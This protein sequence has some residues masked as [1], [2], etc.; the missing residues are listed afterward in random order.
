MDQF[1]DLLLTGGFAPREALLRGLTLEQV[2]TLP[3][4]APHSIFQELWHSTQVLALSLDDGRV[5]LESWPLEEH[6]PAEREPRDERA[7]HDL[8]ERFLAYSR[9]AVSRSH[10]DAWLESQEPGYQSTWR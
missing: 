10:D 4:H 6:F 9:L 1:D 2:G 5:V 3:P 8:V 7:W